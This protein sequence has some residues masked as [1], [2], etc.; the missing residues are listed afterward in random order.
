MNMGYLITVDVSLSR[1][2]KKHFNVVVHLWQF[3]R[4]HLLGKK[5]IVSA[6]V[7]QGRENYVYQRHMH[8]HHPLHSACV[9]DAASSD[10]EMSLWKCGFS[11][12]F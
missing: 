1:D 11:S 2:D 12:E 8:A 6:A 7:K 3:Q 10:G 5:A 9:A 4:I